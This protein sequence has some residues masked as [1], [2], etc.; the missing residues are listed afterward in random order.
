MAKHYS[1]FLLQNRSIA[2]RKFDV[3]AK[4]DADETDIW[5][6]DAIA[7]DDEEAQWWGGT[8]PRA[9]AKEL[10]GIKSGTINLRIN[11]PGGSVFGARAMASALERTHARVVAHVDGL[12]ASAASLLAASADEVV[13]HDGAMLM[14]HDPWG[15][16]VGNAQDMR[17]QAELL[18]KVAGTLAQTYAKRAGKTVDEAREW[19]R[20][21]TWFDADE[22][23]AAGLAD[24]I[25]DAA[26]AEAESPVWNLSAFVGAHKQARAEQPQQPD[27]VV[28]QEEPQ[29]QPDAAQ[30][31]H[32]ERQHQ[33]LAFLNRCNAQH[34]GE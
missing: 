1:K 34:T 19:M 16:S 31:A 23:L 20:A 4:A 14:I 7:S 27:S 26:Q 21:E 28:A 29:P 6:Y 10:Q 8:S 13:M 24:R 3:V 11:S 25:A 30:L 33:R 15:F 2:G 12:A 22:A 9:F 17:E 18:D 5:L 32:R